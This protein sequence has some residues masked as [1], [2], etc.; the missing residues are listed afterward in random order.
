K[1]SFDDGRKLVEVADHF[2]QRRVW[3]HAVVAVLR[4]LGEF[5]LDLFAA[6]G[7]AHDDAVG[8]QLLFVVCETGDADLRFSQEAVAARAV[9]GSDA[10]EAELQGFAAEHGDDPAD[11]A[12]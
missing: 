4:T 7:G 1:S 5:A 3:V 9:S 8:A 10:A 6:L 12:N 11:G 2:E